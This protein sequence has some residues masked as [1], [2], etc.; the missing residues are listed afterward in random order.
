M[1]TQ[2]FGNYL[3]NTSAVTSEQLLAALSAQATAHVN[4]GTLAVHRGYMTAVET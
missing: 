2:A 1:Y 4:L 3:L